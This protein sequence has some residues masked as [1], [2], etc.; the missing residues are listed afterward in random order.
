MSVSVFPSQNNHIRIDYDAERK[1]FFIYDNNATEVLK[2]IRRGVLS[3]RIPGVYPYTVY[4]KYVINDYK[5]ACQNIKNFIDNEEFY[6][7]E[8]VYEESLRKHSENPTDKNKLMVFKSLM[9]KKYEA[10]L[11]EDVPMKYYFSR[12]GFFE[13]IKPSEK[14]VYK[15]RYS[16]SK[17]SMSRD[18][19]MA[20]QCVPDGYRL[21]LLVNDNATVSKNMKIEVVHEHIDI[22]ENIDIPK[23]DIDEAIF[24]MEYITKRLIRDNEYDMRIELMKSHEHDDKYGLNHISKYHILTNKTRNTIEKYKDTAYF[25]KLIKINAN[26]DRLMND[27]ADM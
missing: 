9:S 17:V 5:E 7:N 8:E 4:N 26:A 12:I 6:F 19:T 15:C 2:K 25:K 1:G 24:E 27:I 10:F 23:E 16:S 22:D 13:L 3:G 11:V 18:L 14:I 21:I 20:Q